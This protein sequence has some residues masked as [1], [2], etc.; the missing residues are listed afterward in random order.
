MSDD[1]ILGEF[2]K[3]LALVMNWSPM[4]VIAAL[5]QYV[6]NGVTPRPEPKKS[7]ARKIEEYSIYNTFLNFTALEIMAREY[8]YQENMEKLEKIG[9]SYFK[10]DELREVLK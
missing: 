6:K 7:L 3:D 2:T 1:N 10:V 5:D 8:I 4:R 9:C